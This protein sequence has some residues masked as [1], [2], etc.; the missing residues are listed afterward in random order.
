MAVIGGTAV[1]GGE[2]TVIDVFVGSVIVL[3]AFIDQ[4]RKGVRR[5][6]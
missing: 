4:L 3:A 2:G 6:R 1:S 5:R